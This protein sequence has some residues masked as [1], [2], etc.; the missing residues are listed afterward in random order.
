M[1]YYELLSQEYMVTAVV[2]AAQLK[3][4]AE[5]VR[6]K[7]MRRASVHLLQNA[8]PF[9]AKA[10]HQKIEDLGWETVPHYHLKLPLVLLPKR[11]LG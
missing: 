1:L 7:W 10:S 3:K 9:V 11:F 8:R 5:D 4:H 2:H 6:E